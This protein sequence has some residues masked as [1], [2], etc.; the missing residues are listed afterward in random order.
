MRLLLTTL[1]LIVPLTFILTCKQDEPLGC[2][3]LAADYTINVPLAYDLPKDLRITLDDRLEAD[4]C[5]NIG[6][7]RRSSNTRDTPKFDFLSFLLMLT[8]EDTRMKI[9]IENCTDNS[10]VYAGT[11]AISR[12]HSI[13]CN[14]TIYESTLP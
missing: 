8:D 14:Y 3:G 4:T 9:E 11:L 6:S 12:Y 1:F 13:A 10:L 7:V 5:Q 2:P